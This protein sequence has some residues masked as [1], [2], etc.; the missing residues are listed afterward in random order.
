MR[1]DQIEDVSTWH[2]PTLVELSVFERFYFGTVGM[3]TPL[4]I[5]KFLMNCAGV[6]AGHEV[7]VTDYEKVF[8][9]AF[10]PNITTEHVNLQV[11]NKSESKHVYYQY[12]KGNLPSRLPNTIVKGIPEFG[13]MNAY[14]TQG[15][16]LGKALS[17]YSSIT[18]FLGAWL[19]DTHGLLNQV[20]ILA[21]SWRNPKD[22]FTQLVELMK[23]GPRM[24]SHQN[25]HNTSF[26]VTSTH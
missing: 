4:K 6:G 1:D 11:N 25:T 12:P 19:E 22:M 3:F 8:R 17:A 14:S 21:R 5:I 23:T 24:V 13:R 26:M 16:S 10:P 15:N 7:L 9:K 20:K 2:V 18:L